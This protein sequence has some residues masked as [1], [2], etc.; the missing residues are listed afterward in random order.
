M[1]WIA[2]GT[3]VG[4]TVSVVLLSLMVG[5]KLIRADLFKDFD[6]RYVPVNVCAMKDANVNLLLT[7]TNEKL[8]RVDDVLTGMSETLGEVQ[9]RL[10]RLETLLNNR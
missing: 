9:S 3:L 4:A 5:T 7:T 10:T 8:E 6:K 2:F 1:D